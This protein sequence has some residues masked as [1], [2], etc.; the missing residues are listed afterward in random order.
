MRCPS[1]GCEESR[2]IKTR[3]T[4]GEIKRRRACMACGFRW[5]TV[6]KNAHGIDVALRDPFSDANIKYG[7]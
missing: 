6:E 3:H 5:T 7:P 1:C 2:V 4:R